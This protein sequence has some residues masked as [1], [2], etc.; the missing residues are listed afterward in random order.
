MLALHD[1]SNKRVSKHPQHS[2]VA[3]ID[4]ASSIAARQPWRVVNKPV[5]ILI[6]TRRKLID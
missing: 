1:P 4:R 2:A 5:P 3:E 6:N